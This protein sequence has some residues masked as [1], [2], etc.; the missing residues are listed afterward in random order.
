MSQCFCYNNVYTFLLCTY[1]ST[2]SAPC[3]NTCTS[4]VSVFTLSLKLA[5]RVFFPLQSAHYAHVVQELYGFNVLVMVESFFMLCA[6]LW[7]SLDTTSTSRSLWRSLFLM[8]Q[9]A[10]TMFRS[11]CSGIVVWC[12]YYF[13]WCKPRVGYR[14]SKRV[15][16]FVYIVVV[17]YEGT[18]RSSFLSANIFFLYLRPS[19]SHLFLTWVPED[20]HVS[21]R[22]KLEVTW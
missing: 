17:C 15:S 8:Y 1:T 3:T 21:S 4:T 18:V 12:L 14:M 13:V 11:I 9:V 19:S 16:V 20:G 7:I 6:N 22:N 10:L 5:E 2:V